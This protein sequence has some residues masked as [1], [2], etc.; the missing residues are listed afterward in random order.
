MNKRPENS[1]SQQPIAPIREDSAVE[2]AFNKETNQP[3]VISVKPIYRPT[4]KMSEPV[5]PY[6]KWIWLIVIVLAVLAWIFLYVHFSNHQA[7]YAAPLK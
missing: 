6:W 4:E 7:P 2:V 3:E 1:A 5:K